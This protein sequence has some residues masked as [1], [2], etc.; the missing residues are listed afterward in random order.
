MARRV[1]T[2]VENHFSE[3]I[4]CS[5][6]FVCSVCLIRPAHLFALPASFLTTCVFRRCTE[7]FVLAR[8]KAQMLIYDS[9]RKGEG[10]VSFSAANRRF[11]TRVTR[12]WE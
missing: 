7:T 12:E 10:T 1:P 11:S 4:P 5:S 2:Y 6:R 3:E 8:Q 9:Y